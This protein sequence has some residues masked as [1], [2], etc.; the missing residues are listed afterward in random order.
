MRAAFIAADAQAAQCFVP[1][2]QAPGADKWLADLPALARQRLH[3]LGI[4]AI[5]GND[6]SA[7]WCTVGNPARFFSHRRDGGVTGRQAGVV[8][9]A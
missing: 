1:Y 7:P 2:A 6:G 5:Y 8:W 9:R 4:T 3:R